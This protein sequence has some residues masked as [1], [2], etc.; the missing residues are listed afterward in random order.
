MKHLASN[1]ASLC[2]MLR[3]L[4]S[5]SQRPCYT[6]AGADLNDFLID[7]GSGAMDASWRSFRPPETNS[8]KM[9]TLQIFKGIR[10]KQY[11]TFFYLVLFL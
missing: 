7:H 1:A 11:N 4:T 5:D 9:T 10:R 8:L 3:N 2:R 6:V